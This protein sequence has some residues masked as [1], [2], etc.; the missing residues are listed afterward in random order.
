MHN[1][2]CG[3][4]SIE[5]PTFVLA[6]RCNNPGLRLHTLLLSRT[7]SNASLTES[8]H[9]PAFAISISV[10]LNGRLARTAAA[11]QAGGFFQLQGA[12]AHI[13]ALNYQ[14]IL[15]CSFH[16]AGCFLLGLR[17]PGAVLLIHGVQGGHELGILIQATGSLLI[18][19]SSIAHK[20]SDI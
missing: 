2:E 5:C 7:E 10:D 1:A 6:G 3:A 13:T 4:V 15:L 12:L 20:S 17:L 14:F 19:Q 8:Q 9:G 16:C 11:G 18:T